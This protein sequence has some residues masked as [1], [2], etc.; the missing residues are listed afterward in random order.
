MGCGVW[1]VG[2]G[3]WGVGCGMWGVGCGVLGVDIPHLS[4]NVV[5]EIARE[6]ALSP[7]VELLHG[8]TSVSYKGT[9]LI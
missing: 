2:C 3:V 7:H 8:Q 9:S 6:L 1:G 5:E 4:E